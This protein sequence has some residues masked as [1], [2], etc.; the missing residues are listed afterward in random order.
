M[1]PKYKSLNMNDFSGGWN[2]VTGAMGLP[3]NQSPDC[4]N[5][6]PLPGKLR[7]RGGTINKVALPHPADHAF[8]FYDSAGG[9]HYAIWAGGT[10]YDVASGA[11]VTVDAA[12]YTS[13]A[14]VKIG[15]CVLN[16]VLLWSVG[17]AWTPV[18]LRFWNPA[19]STH[20]AVTSSTGVG[21]VDAPASSFLFTYLN[22]VYALSPLWGKVGGSGT[23]VYQKNVMAISEVNDYTSWPA[24][25]SQAVGPN[26]GG[27]LVAG[28]QMG[29]SNTGVPPARNLLILRSDEGVYAYTGAPPSLVE[30]VLNCPVG[31][32]DADSVQFVPALD[33]LGGIIWLGTDGQFWKSNGI[34]C[35]PICQNTYNYIINAVGNT[36]NNNANAR[37]RSFY[38][39]VWQY[40][41]CDVNGTQFAYFYNTGA[42]SKFQGWPSGPT[43]STTGFTGAPIYYVASSAT[44]NPYVAQ[45]AVDNSLDNGSM[46]STYWTTPFL[47]GGDLRGYKSFDWITLCPLDTGVTYR[48]QGISNK[49]SDNTY[50]QSDSALLAAPLGGTAGSGKF[51]LGV[52]KLGGPDV[53]GSG[54]VSVASAIPVPMQTKMV[55]SV[56]DDPYLLPGMKESLK[57][58]AAQYTIKWAA[59]QAAFDLLWIEVQYAPLGEQRGAGGPYNPVVNSPAVFDPWN[60]PAGT[61]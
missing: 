53:L 40:Y 11:V 58:V 48:V 50:M 9:K 1:A 18:K 46:P 61:G 24:A 14:G 22:Q 6:L 54:S 17:D 32:L 49:R 13:V 47:H 39:D 45:I 52:S 4:L 34:N 30:S 26:N 36:L 7:F 37:F 15:A 19:A 60:S 38:N 59:G 28:L 43:F 42:W 33:G 20:G 3:L 23:D 41:S 5:V 31:C 44:S 16:G 10:L 35:L 51:I 8:P 57:G 55:C 27:T 29:I 12:S 56:P 25:T 21:L 2:V